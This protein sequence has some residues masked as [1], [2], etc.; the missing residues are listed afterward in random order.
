MRFNP[1]DALLLL[2][3]CG[4][5]LD[6]SSAQ[7][8]IPK[9][10]SSDASAWVTGGN[11]GRERNPIPSRML[12]T[13]DGLS[14]IAAAL[15]SRAHLG[16][17]PDCSHLV[18]AIY[19]RAGFQYSYVS[20]SDLYTGINEFQRVKHP[21]PGDLVVWPGHVGIVINPAQHLFFSTLH[22]G[23]GVDSYNAPYWRGRGRARFYRYIKL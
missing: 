6:A 17:K 16:F 3:L 21:Q 9:G 12:G 22:S 5:A 14:V 13:D 8:N 7:Q 18:H 2:A 23:P 10:K 20:S 4:L 15:E 19:E 1:K 11:A